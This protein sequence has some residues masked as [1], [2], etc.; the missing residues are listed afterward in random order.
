MKHSQITSKPLYNTDYV[1]WVETTLEQLRSRDYNNVDWDNLLDEIEDMSR[2][3][4]QSLK[5]NLVVILLHLLKWQFQPNYRTGSWA[6]SMTEHRRRVL[7]SLEES[8]SLKPYLESVLAKCYQSAR[9]QAHQETGLPLEMF[10][11][12]CQYKVEEILDDDFFPEVDRG[13]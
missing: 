3:E 7:E 10:P 11:S 6:G 8:P 12:V 9:K 4:H 5:S 1:R 13:E 2:R